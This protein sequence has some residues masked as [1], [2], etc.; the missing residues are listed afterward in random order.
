MSLI[1]DAL[2][3]AKQAQEQ[4][5]PPPVPS[6]HFRPVEPGPSHP[7]AR[8]LAVMLLVALASILLLG[9]VF[10]RQLAQKGGPALQAAA[11]TPSTSVQTRQ[12]AV[13]P[14]P[15][16]EAPAL[17]AAMAAAPP[18]PGAN[19]PSVAAPVPVSA[20]APEGTGATPAA[21][22]TEVAAPKPAPLRLQAIVFRSNHSSAMISGRT[23][24]VGDKLGELRVVAIEQNRVK[25][26]SGGQTNVLELPE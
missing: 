17:K 3:R 12:P 10:F 9:L 4:A 1:N 25:L 8:G 23:L 6:L 20:A 7:A 13:Q 15:Q 24:F 22:A 19:I 11:R 21:A 14:T 5:P 26:V 18:A 2:K 16:P